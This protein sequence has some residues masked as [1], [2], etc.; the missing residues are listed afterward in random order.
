MCVCI[1]GVAGGC[2][3]RKPGLSSRHCKK[4]GLLLYHSI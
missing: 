3:V 4:G 1:A 2:N